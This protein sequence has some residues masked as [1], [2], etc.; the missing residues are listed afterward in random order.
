MSAIKIFAHVAAFVIPL[1]DMQ[2]DHVLKKLT[3]DPT[4]RVGGSAFRIF[5]TMLLHSW[6]SFIWYAKWPCSEKKMNFNLLTQ[7]QM[8]KGTGGSAGQ[9]YATMLLY[10]WFPLIW[11]ATWPCSDKV[12]FR[13]F[14]HTSSLCV[15]VWGGGGVCG[16]NICYHS[17]YLH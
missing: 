16:K 6:F 17:P 7:S 2:H 3:I 15:C 8:G 1:I 11:Y 13:R 4:T 12:L 14:D 5:A 9:I 10:S